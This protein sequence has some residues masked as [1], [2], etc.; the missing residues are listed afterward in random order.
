MTFWLGF[1]CGCLVSPAA[2]LIVIAALDE[3][4]ARRRPKEIGSYVERTR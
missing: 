1:G 3:L 2:V 4:A